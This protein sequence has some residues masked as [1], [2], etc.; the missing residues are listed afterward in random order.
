MRQFT[1]RF[2]TSKRSEEIGHMEPEP[3]F[4]GKQ[5]AFLSFDLK[6]QS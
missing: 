6:G 4:T 3:I 5:T 1:R 2:E